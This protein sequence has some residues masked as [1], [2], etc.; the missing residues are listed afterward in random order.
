[1]HTRPL[2]TFKPHSITNHNSRS[3]GQPG[4]QAKSKSPP[5]I[6]AALSSNRR[7]EAAGIPTA[8]TVPENAPCASNDLEAP[9][10]AEIQSSQPNRSESR[11][12]AEPVATDIFQGSLIPRN[13]T[14]QP[15]NAAQTLPDGKVHKQVD[16]GDILRPA[17]S[18][19]DLPESSHDLRD[20]LTHPRPRSRNKNSDSYTSRYGTT[21]VPTSAPPRRPLTEHQLQPQH[22]RQNQ[23]IHSTRDSRVSKRGLPRA[24]SA[25]NMQSN[26]RIPMGVS[27]TIT[28]AEMMQMAAVIA[29]AEKEQRKQVVAKTQLQEVQI[30]NLGKANSALQNQIECLSK[31]NQ[32]LV[33][34]HAGFRARCEKYKANMNDVMRAQKELHAAAVA[35]DKRKFDVLKQTSKEMDADTVK[36]KALASG[37]L[38]AIMKEARLKLDRR[39]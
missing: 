8:A 18:D 38:R 27:E 24:K 23:D 32:E 6:E 11:S 15:G 26:V 21:E 10:R 33:E 20:L 1:M 12:V 36:A 13:Q 25:Y 7:P 39:K 22:I 2:A 3:P 34:K 5:F 29:T 17:V 4:R 9:R 35:L 19:R 14:D 37:E 16:Y 31:D 28:S 30:V